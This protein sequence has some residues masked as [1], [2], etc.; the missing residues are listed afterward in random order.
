VNDREPIAGTGRLRVLTWHIHGSYLWYLSHL[1]H[2]ILLPTRPDG[3]GHDNSGGYGGR[4]GTFPWPD[5][6]IEV[7]A[8][9]VA[10]RDDIDVVL[11][12]HH[13]N[14]LEDQH[15]ILSPA[16]RR[17]PRVFLEHDPPRTSPFDAPH[18]VDDPDVLVV[19]VTPFNR[20]MWDNGAVP[21]A[22]VEH[23]VALLPAD[24]RWTGE[25]DRGLVVVN[26]LGRRGRRL[27][28]DVFDAVRARVPL[29][30]VGMGSEELGGLGE[31]KPPGLP[32]FAA[33]YRFVFNPI[34]WTSLGLAVCE[35]MAAGV[36]IVGLATTEMATAVENGV[37][38]YVDTDVDRLVERMEALLAD[39]AAAARLSDGA[40]RT[41]RRRFGID[42]FVADWDAVLRRVADRRPPE[43]HQYSGATPRPA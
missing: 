22:V 29:D 27:G 40:R 13:R 32:A 38:G 26:H 6:V 31:I 42:R 18:P 23:G 15:E 8:D 11:F 25:F 41:A 34:R 33:R 10:G 24:V 20:L 9:E 19:H 43:L 17:G 12:Q 14:W 2:D 5:N 28:L 36:P 35:A 21:T 3:P 39:R 7:P 1:P 16:Q 30:L 37:S 4:A